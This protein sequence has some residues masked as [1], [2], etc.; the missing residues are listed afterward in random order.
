MVFLDDLT[1]TET[2]ATTTRKKNKIK[3]NKKVQIDRETE[4]EIKVKS[5]RKWKFGVSVIKLSVCGE[6]FVGRCVAGVCVYYFFV[7]FFSF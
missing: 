7:F 4:R 5:H 6:K 3:S 2:H 1:R